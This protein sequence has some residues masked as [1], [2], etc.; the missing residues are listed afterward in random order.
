VGDDRRWVTPSDLAEYAFC[1]RALH[2]RWTRDDPGSEPAARGTA[3]HRRRLSA[4]RR[5]D[6]HGRLA[7]V[8]V[9]LGAILVLVAAVLAGGL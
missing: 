8:A 9:A 7:W 5:R 2:Y 6:E 4:E 3:Y 1:P